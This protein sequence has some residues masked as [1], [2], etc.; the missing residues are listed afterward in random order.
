MKFILGTKKNMTEYFAENGH[1]IPVTIVEAGP[2]TVTRILEKA[3]DGYDAVQ[4]GFGGQKKERI[5]KARLGQMKGVSYRFLKEFRLKPGEKIEAKE[6]IPK[7][8]DTDLA[9][10]LYELYREM[11]DEMKN[12]KLLNKNYEH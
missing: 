8:K 2:V 10:E 4:V 11:G 6:V 9:Q 7:K 1:V 3:K 5:T 12:I